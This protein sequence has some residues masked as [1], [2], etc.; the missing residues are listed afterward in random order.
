MV[1]LVT[2]AEPCT[3]GC[4]KY[5]IYSLGF[6]ATIVAPALPAPLQGR[7]KLK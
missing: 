7:E 1:A 2:L 3:V 5:Q 6:L 4:K